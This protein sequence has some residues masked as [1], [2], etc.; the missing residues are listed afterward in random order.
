MNHVIKIILKQL[1]LIV[2]DV[3]E[4]ISRTGIITHTT[5]TYC[6]YDVIRLTCTC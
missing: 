6:I 4:Y 2:T 3:R 1:I 5:H